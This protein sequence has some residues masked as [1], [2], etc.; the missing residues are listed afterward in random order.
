M[1]ISQPIIFGL[2]L[3]ALLTIPAMIAMFGFA[4]WWGMSRADV[5]IDADEQARRMDAPT[6]R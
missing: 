5:G 6:R 3:P 1:D 2:D 4:V